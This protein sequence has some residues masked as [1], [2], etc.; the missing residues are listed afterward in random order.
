ML[1][2]SQGDELEIVGTIPIDV[3]EILNEVQSNEKKCETNY[4]FS[5]NN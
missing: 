1:I 5:N 4:H 3:N 2:S